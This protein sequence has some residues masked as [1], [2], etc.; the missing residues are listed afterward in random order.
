MCRSRKSGVIDLAEC[1]DSEDNA[2]TGRLPV[3]ALYSLTGRLPQGDMAPNER[4]GDLELL[5]DLD[6]LSDRPASCRGTLPS[7]STPS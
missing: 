6:L 7:R 2:L 4:T 3:S 1:T 5:A